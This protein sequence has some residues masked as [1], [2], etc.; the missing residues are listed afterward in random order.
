ML[1]FEQCIEL[2]QTQ[3]RE[4]PFEALLYSTPS[5]QKPDTVALG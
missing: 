3:Y 1:K 5:G 2:P 4:P